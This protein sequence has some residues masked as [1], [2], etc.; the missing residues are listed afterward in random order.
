M[1]D[2]GSDQPKLTVGSL[3]GLPLGA[4]PVPR[5]ADEMAPAPILQPA[6]IAPQESL[7]TE[8]KPWTVV[9]GTLMQR[10]AQDPFRADGVEALTYDNAFRQP[11]EQVWFDGKIVYAL[12]LGAIDVD[13]SRV[14]V[15]QEYQVVYGVEL[16]EQGHTKTEPEPVPGQLN[17]YDSV[18]GMDKYSPIWQFDY[19]VVPRDY[20]PNTLRSERDCLTSGYPVHRSQVFEN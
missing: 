1:P 3:L 17:I 11:I 5:Q 18:P 13:P 19:V 8:E 9:A 6:Q 4:T 7:T 10:P 12:D 20:P 14:K 16:D 15:A 2:D